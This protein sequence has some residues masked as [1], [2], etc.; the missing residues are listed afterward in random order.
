MDKVM[1]ETGTGAGIRDKD[2]GKKEDKRRRQSKQPAR[3]SPDAWVVSRLLS[4]P[5]SKTSKWKNNLPGNT[6]FHGFSPLVVTP[7]CHFD[8]MAEKMENLVRPRMSW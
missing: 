6:F 7:P 5:P 8:R 4:S 2:E 1:L 3:R